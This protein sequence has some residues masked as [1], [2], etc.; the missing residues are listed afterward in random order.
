MKKKGHEA[1]G[2]GESVIL[3]CHEPLTPSREPGR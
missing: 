1:R 2:A 3:S